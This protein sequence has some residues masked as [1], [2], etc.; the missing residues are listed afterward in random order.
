MQDTTKIDKTDLVDVND[1][2][3]LFELLKPYLAHCLNLNHDLNNPLSG[4]V[5]YGELL[6]EETGDWTDSQRDTLS[7]MLKCAER[8]R[9]ILEK[10][11]EQKIELSQQVDLRAVMEKFEK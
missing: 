6:I 11:S 3:A 4:V 9:Q 10:L 2:R 8:M 1:D 7:E 5:G